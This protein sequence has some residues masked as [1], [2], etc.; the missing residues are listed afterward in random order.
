MLFY[1]HEKSNMQFIFPYMNITSRQ[2][3]RS[4]H[5]QVHVADL[6]LC[7]QVDKIILHKRK[8]W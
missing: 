4:Y 5:D 8:V 3:I 6:L 2:K 1:C 7:M